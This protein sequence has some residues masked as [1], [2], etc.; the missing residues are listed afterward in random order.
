MLFLSNQYP[1]GAR[2]R[3]WLQDNPLG[4][5]SYLTCRT[6]NMVDTPEHMLIVCP[7][8]NSTRERL[9]LIG[10]KQKTPVSYN[11]IT[12]QLLLHQTLNLLRIVLDCSTAA[13]TFENSVYDDLLYIARTWCFSI[14][15]ERLK[16]SAAGTFSSYKLAFYFERLLPITSCRHE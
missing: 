9:L 10:L 11:I 12:I 13:Q 5:Y 16:C 15:R 6:P 3:H 1:C 2:T 7:V 8:F 4:L 14:C